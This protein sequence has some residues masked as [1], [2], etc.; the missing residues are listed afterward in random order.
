MKPLFRDGILIETQVTALALK[1]RKIYK[2]ART[3]GICGQP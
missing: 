1:W 3:L 2:H